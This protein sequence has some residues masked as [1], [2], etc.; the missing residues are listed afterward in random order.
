MVDSAA[1]NARVRHRPLG[2]VDDAIE[3]VG[4][5]LVQLGAGQ[6]LV[7]VLRHGVHSVMNGRLI[8]VSWAEESSVFAF[9]A[10]W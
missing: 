8:C 7:E 3:Q 1:V 10:S 2:R 6:T 9:S 4:G 5:Q